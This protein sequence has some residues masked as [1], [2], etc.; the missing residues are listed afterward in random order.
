MSDN[1]FADLA[2]EQMVSPVKA[3]R[4][5]VETRRQR[6]EDKRQSDAQILAQQWRDWHAKRLEE[7]Q[8]GRWRE[9]ALTVAKFL[10]R[11]TLEDGAA[12]EQLVE[13]GPWRDTDAD[14]RF[15]ILGMIS[16]RIVFLREREGW[17]PFDDSMPFSDEEP[18]VFEIIKELLR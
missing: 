5:A 7:L 1:P 11:M 4:R 13:H 8:T 9:P 17:L 3:R 10:E 16:A 2:D 15:L 12:L 18:T 14:T 6:Q